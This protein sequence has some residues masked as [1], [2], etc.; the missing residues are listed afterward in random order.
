MRHPAEL[1]ITV[2]V[3]RFCFLI[4]ESMSF[5]GKAHYPQFLLPSLSTQMN[6]TEHVLPRDMEQGDHVIGVEL[7]VPFGPIYCAAE[8]FFVL[9]IEKEDLGMFVGP[10]LRTK[11]WELNTCK[12]ASTRRAAP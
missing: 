1:S 9:K 2:H 12:V 8:H 6:R 10:E 11:L 3:F 4:V 5:M 7:S